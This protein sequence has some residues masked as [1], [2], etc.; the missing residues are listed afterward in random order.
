MAV[1]E[2][3]LTDA[4]LR[5]Q[6]MLLRLSEGERD[7]FLPFLREIDRS[8]RDRLSRDELTSYSRERLERLL[9]AVDAM[10]AE[11][12]G[13][14]RST[15]FDDLDDVLKDEARF[16]ARAL[17]DI[18]EFET[19]I[20]GV[21]QIRAAVFANPLSIKN[22]SLLKSFVEDWTAAERKAVTGA[23]RRGVFEGQTNAQIVRAIRGTRARQYQDGLLQITARNARTIVHTA[24]QHTSNQARQATFDA[25]ADIVKGTRWIS[26]LDTITCQSCRSLDQREFPRDKGPRPPLHPFCLP[27]DALVTT[28][29]RITGASK[30]WFD[31]DLV[32]ISTS[33]GKRLACTPNHPVLTRRGWVG[34]REVQIGDD[35]VCDIT[36][37]TVGGGCDHQ[38]VP[39]RIQ[40]VAETFLSSRQVVSV[41]VPTAAEHFHGDGIDGEIAVV[42]S[43]RFLRDGGDTAALELSHERCLICGRGPSILLSCL[44]S[45]AKFLVRPWLS[46]DGGMSGFEKSLAFAG[47]GSV[48][49]SLLLRGAISK[50]DPVSLERGYEC[51]PADPE[52]LGYAGD[53]HAGLEEAFRAAHRYGLHRSFGLA[54][55]MDAASGEAP[56]D[57]A[58][59]YTELARDVLNG[60]FGPIEFDRI[61]D[62]SVR[63]FSGHVFNLETESGFYSANG[64]VN[65]NC[66][67]TTVPVLIDKFRGLQDG[68]TRA[69][70][71]GQVAANLSYYEWLKTQPK[72]VIEMALGPKRAKLFL[73]GGISAER[74]AAMQLDRRWEPLTLEEM[75]KLEP[76]AFERAGL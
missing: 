67:C 66:R 74:F 39:S 9:K 18:V 2:S 73:E 51:P 6:V 76:L 41:P 15:L 62:K 49:P 33:G 27:G 5:R 37:R 28:G 61:I 57:D 13:E 40:D 71:N 29:H 16:A 14:F 48:H 46:V 24:V 47:A 17:S 3:Y 31:G 38:D 4:L 68:G 23:I 56:I 36:Y 20:P 8:I 7:K 55:D 43:D 54:E 1:A 25:H 45:L 21:Q 69:S 52:R 32:V 10:M 50:R 65:H 44:R 60:V 59:G 42:G 26:T 35:V 53:T 64:I 34:A 30:R 70:M 11:V 58:F 72:S 22:G 12:L 75:R 19:A 63:S